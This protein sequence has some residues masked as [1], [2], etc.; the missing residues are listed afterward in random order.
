M[1]NRGFGGSQ[2]SDV[3]TCI[4]ETVKPSPQ[5]W[6]L[7]PRMREVNERIRADAQTHARLHYIDLAAP[8]LGAD[9]KPRPELFV[10]DGLHM[11][12]AGYDGWSSSVRRLLDSIPARK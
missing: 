11:T 2:L 8:M 12:P 1:V 9:G 7:W 5:R 4:T 10:A 3:N 6:A